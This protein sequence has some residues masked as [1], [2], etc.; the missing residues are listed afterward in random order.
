MEVMSPGP[1]TITLEREPE[2]QP[3]AKAPL[4]RILGWV[5]LLALI[6]S[7]V[8]GSNAFAVRDRLFGSATPN[9]APPAAGR[10][11]GNAAPDTRAAARTNL[12][13]QPW[14]Q[15]VATLDGSGTTASA[16]FTIA[17]GVIQWRVKWTCDSGHL[18]VRAP[19]QAKPMVDSACPGGTA[20]YSTQSGPMTVQ[21]TADGPW[22]L[23][24]AQQIDA[25]LVEPP[26]P[27]MTAP[28]A[29]TVGT[30]SFYNVDKTGMGKVTVY[31]QADG[32]YSVRLEDFFVSLNSDLELRLSTLDAPHN[33]QDVAD[34]QSEL[35]A[36]MDVTAGSL[37]YA[38]PAGVDPTRFRSVVVWC[39]PISSAYTAATLR[40]AG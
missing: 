35:V 29:T 39:R 27:A 21:V 10:V 8:V 25:P 17:P 7:A 22:H 5:G 20:G 40:T 28:G 33:S 1:D 36:V 6:F 26:L 4:R 9:A 16:P 12:R 24:V 30:G 14:W 3:P 2:A 15:D 23:Q 13:S 34:A 18:L 38:V 37:N 11:A 19:R 32:N 31:R